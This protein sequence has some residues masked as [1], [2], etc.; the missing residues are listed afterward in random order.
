MMNFRPSVL[1]GSEDW[2]EFHQ[3]LGLFQSQNGDLLSPANSR[4]Q[5]QFNHNHVLALS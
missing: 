4:K 5:F 2:D 1:F 3:D